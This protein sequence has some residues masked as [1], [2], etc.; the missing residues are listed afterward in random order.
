MATNPA[1]PVDRTALLD[2]L[3]PNCEPDRVAVLYPKGEKGLSP[4]W[5]T[6]RE[7]VTRALAA[8]RNGTLADEAFTAVTKKGVKYRIIG[9]ARLGLIPHRNGFVLVFCVDL[10]DHE[11]NGGNVHILAALKRF[12]GAEPLVFTSKSGAG[13]HVFFRLREPMDSEAFVAWAR[14][15]GF[16]RRGQP[17]VFP[18]TSKNTQAWLPNE[19]NDR[20]G[21]T[22]QGGSL[23]GCIVASL[24]EPPPTQLTNATL[25][26]LRGFV[27]AGA[28]NEALNK[29]A[30]ELGSKGVDRAEAWRL[31]KL[32]AMICGL[33]GEELDQTVCLAVVVVLGEHRVDA[34]GLAAEPPRQSDAR[35]D[36]RLVDGIGV[37]QRRIV[38]GPPQQMVDKGQARGIALQLLPRRRQA[39]GAMAS[40]AAAREV[41]VRDVPIAGIHALLRG[42]GAIVPA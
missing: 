16:N 26:F 36:A 12:F 3:A 33:H 23:E 34:A 42:Y 1:P 11:G 8:Y 13:L 5:V 20:G 28:R 30:F 6:G 29:A 19:P 31:C 40:L 7:D 18:K 27:S 14:A 15:W 9:G 35:R 17:E 2:W 41:D 22:F 24:P 38:R 4:G 21:D 37:G 39:A 25:D 32:G 10:D